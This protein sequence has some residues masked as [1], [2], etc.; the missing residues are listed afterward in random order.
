MSKSWSNK[1]KAQMDGQAHQAKPDADNM[2]KAL[3]DAM[4]S[5]DSGVW[6]VRITK[7]GDTK[8]K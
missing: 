6:D 8:A 2:L 1:K 5:D 3:C 4:Y 7:V